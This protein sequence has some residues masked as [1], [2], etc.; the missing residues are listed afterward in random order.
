MKLKWNKFIHILR[1][2]FYNLNFYHFTTGSV[3]VAR[4]GP[5]RKYWI[6]GH[7]MDEVTKVGITT[8]RGHYYLENPSPEFRDKMKEFF[9]KVSIQSFLNLCRHEKAGSAN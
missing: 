8:D 3:P 4:G 1:R 9:K 6:T 2:S 7:G 5:V